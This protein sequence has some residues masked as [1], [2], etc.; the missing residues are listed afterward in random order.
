MENTP[1]LIV[2]QHTNMIPKSM[3]TRFHPQWI[4]PFFSFS[5]I[6][7]LALFER[8]VPHVLL[9][10]LSFWTHKTYGCRVI[11]FSTLR[12]AHIYLQVCVPFVANQQK[13]CCDEICVIMLCASVC[14]CVFENM[15]THFFIFT[16]TIFSFPILLAT[17]LCDV[18]PLWGPFKRI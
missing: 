16:L 14:I 12:V 4:V 13:K 10:P 6:F 3:M 9:L 2:K 5:G 1:K 15:R 8:S 7:F 17:P 11:L 18:T